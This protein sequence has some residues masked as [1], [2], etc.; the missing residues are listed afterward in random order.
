MRNRIIVIAL[1]LVISLITQIQAQQY[2]YEVNL[3]A[4]VI[5]DLGGLQSYAYGTHD[6]EWLIV[7][8]R[9]DGLHMRQP[10]ASFNAAGNNDQLMVINPE[11]KEVWKATVS[12][13][14]P[15]IREQLSSTNMQF[16]QEEENLII[17]GGYAYSPTADEHITF[18]YLTVIKIPEVINAI[19]AG[20]SILDF[21]EQIEDEKFAVAGGRLEKMDDQFYLVG[22][23]KFTGRYNP[24]GPAHGPGFKQEYTYEI[25]PFSIDIDEEIIVTHGTAMRDEEHLRRRDYNL[26]P[27]IRNGSEELMLFSGV[28]QPDYNV[29]WLYPVSITASSY[30]PQINFTQYYNHYHCATLPIYHESTD[31]MH[32]LFFGGIAQFYDDN[33]TLVQDNDV[34]FVK[35]IAD[36]SRLSDGTLIEQKLKEEMPALLGAGAEFIRLPD[37]PIYKGKVLDGDLLTTQPLEV[38]YIFGG[39]KSTMPNVFW[40]NDGTQ[41]VASGTI[42]KVSVNKALNT[43][44]SVQEKALPKILIYPNPSENFV[45]LGLELDKIQDV[46]IQIYNTAG[47]KVSTKQ[48]R[49][50]ELLVGQ[51]IIICD[52]LDLEFGIYLFE[53][54]IGDLMFSRKLVVAD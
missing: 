14:P 38:G 52:E 42:Y 21:F 18:P 47:A 13:L 3:E 24:M 37:A 4:I 2:T 49:K 45:Y 35:T 34:P 44:V 33:G 19:K 50:G 1:A 9:L 22:G 28:F 8:G 17:T 40:V 46:K 29:P 36:V 51:N 43:S 27:Q 31:E 54:M 6:G 25:R 7:G 48:I 11:S 26:I 53:I 16:G 15:N 12:T 5:P 20:E 32:N 41:S 23:H 39:I 10:F 30:E